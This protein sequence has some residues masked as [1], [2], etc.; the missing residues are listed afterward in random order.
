MLLMVGGFLWLKQSSGVVLFVLKYQA[1]TVY[2][3]ALSL[4]CKRTLK[5]RA[6][7]VNQLQRRADAAMFCLFLCSK[8]YI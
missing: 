7:G 5:I 8:S 1:S 2:I 4:C 6:S 3:V